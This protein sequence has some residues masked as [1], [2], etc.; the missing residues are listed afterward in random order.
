ME[1]EKCAGGPKLRA[2]GPRTTSRAYL[3]K[4]A[5]KPPPEELAKLG[6]ARIHTGRDPGRT[7]FG[8]LGPNEVLGPPS[9]ATEPYYVLVCYAKPMGRSAASFA[10]LIDVTQLWAV[11]ERALDLCR[12]LVHTQP[13]IGTTDRLKDAVACIAPHPAMDLDQL[14]RD[15]PELK[16]LDTSNPRSRYSGTTFFL[17]YTQPVCSLDLSPDLECVDVFERIDWSV[18]RTY[19]RVTLARNL[20]RSSKRAFDARGARPR[21]WSIDMR[22][23]SKSAPGRTPNDIQRKMTFNAIIDRSIGQLPAL[24]HD[25]LQTLLDKYKLLSQRAQDVI[26][27]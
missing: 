8:V 1:I 27:R 23:G 3:I 7:P 2:L 10:A 13:F 17:L 16:E 9:L 20:L 12:H 24:T 5:H 6:E 18:N 4:Y 25:Q 11:P 15:V 22:R 19:I 26:W 14:L 21:I